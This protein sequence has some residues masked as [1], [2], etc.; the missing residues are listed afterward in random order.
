MSVR[1]ED[2]DGEECC[3][4]SFFRHGQ[5]SALAKESPCSVKANFYIIENIT[6]NKAFTIYLF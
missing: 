5:R 6:M 4:K 3:G 1:R 2:K